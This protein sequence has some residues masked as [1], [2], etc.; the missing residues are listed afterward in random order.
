MSSPTPSPEFVELLGSI[1]SVEGWMSDEQ[2]ARLW[3]RAR[4]LGPGAQVVEIGSYR[5]RSIIVLA[6]AAPADTALVAIDPHAGNDRG[7]RQRE[8]AASDG[9][10]DH[11]AFVTNL[12]SAGVAGRIRHVRKPSDAA[13]ADVDG[14]IDLLYI[15]GAH[16]YRAAR[17]DI[18]DW[19]A[20]V[21]PGGTMLVHDAFSS[22]GVTLALLRE[23]FLSRS[24]T[25]LGR[26]GSM[27][28]YQ[29]APVGRGRRATNLARQVAQ[30][31]WFIR[32]LVVKVLIV[33]RL[34]KAAR[35]LGHREGPWPF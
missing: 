16:T 27:V 20:R 10:A 5:G 28:E 4:S 35:L 3:Q 7:P 33:L 22:V 19:G 24:L 1:R 2:A 13:L 14:P 25:Y 18:R 8:G 12:R 26:S 17:A 23:T 9:Q 30:L 6:T 15:D 21:A 32:N 11:E 29:R 31:P 34:P